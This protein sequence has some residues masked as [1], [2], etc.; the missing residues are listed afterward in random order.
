MPKLT[1]DDL[2]RIKEE[3]RTSTSLREGG[4]KAK[5]TVHMD[6]GSPPAPGR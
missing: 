5:V 6:S 2:K 4:Y 3:V 1:L